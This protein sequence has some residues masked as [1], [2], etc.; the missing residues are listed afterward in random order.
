MDDFERRLCDQTQKLYII[1]TFYMSQMN[2]KEFVHNTA[3]SVQ[4]P[5]GIQ[6]YIAG[7]S[8]SGFKG[9]VNRTSPSIYD[10]ICILIYL[11]LFNLLVQY[12]V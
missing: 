2:P 1:K 11:S 6:P 12:L 8:L 7:H 4:P 3:Y 5:Y 10:N 9:T